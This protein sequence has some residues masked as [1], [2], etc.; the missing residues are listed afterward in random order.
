MWKLPVSGAR[1]QERV[2]EVCELKQRLADLEAEHK[3]VL[4]Q[5]VWRLSGVALDPE[6]LPK[7]YRP[8]KPKDEAA[9]YI[10]DP[11]PEPK[12]HT[13]ARAR[14]TYKK[15]KKSVSRVVE[16][17]CAQGADSISSRQSL[18][19][20][21]EQPELKTKNPARTVSTRTHTP[22]QGPAIKGGLRI[23]LPKFY[24]LAVLSRRIQCIV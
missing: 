20:H 4:N 7:S 9:N 2:A 16:E 21:W 17:E 24:T 13:G 19:G 8:A 5:F 23:G 6:L 12:A 10:S 15:I 1:Y 14:L 11:K 22:R 3:K 18:Q